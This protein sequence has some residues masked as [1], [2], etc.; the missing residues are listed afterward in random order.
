MTGASSEQ[1][2][3]LRNRRTAL[4]SRIRKR[5]VQKTPTDELV[6]SSETD[7][8]VMFINETAEVLKDHSELMKE[9]MRSMKV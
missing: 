3:L 4:Q 6:E 5:E 8:T 1:K 9:I 2:R 7:P